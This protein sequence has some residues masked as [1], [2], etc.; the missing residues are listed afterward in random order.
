MKPEL[1]TTVV[2]IPGTDLC[3]PIGLHAMAMSN[4]LKNHGLVWGKD[5]DWHIDQNRNETRFRFHNSAVE[6]ASLFLLRW[7]NREIY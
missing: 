6:Y 2:A 7:R 3:K 1:I 5:Y 4:W